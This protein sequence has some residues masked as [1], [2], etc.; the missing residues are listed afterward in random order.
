MDHSFSSC[1]KKMKA[2]DRHGLSSSLKGVTVGAMAALDG[3][4]RVKMRLPISASRLDQTI[5]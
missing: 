5:A 1:N 4:G 2:V 3:E